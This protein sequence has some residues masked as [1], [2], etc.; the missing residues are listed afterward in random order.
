MGIELA[1]SP[2]HEMLAYHYQVSAQGTHR[3]LKSHQ[4]ES[5]NDSKQTRIAYRQG[6]IIMALILTPGRGRD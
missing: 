5:H 6:P 2:L 3:T 4:P 1:L